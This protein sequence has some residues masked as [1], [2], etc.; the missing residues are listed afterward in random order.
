MLD[1]F[2]RRMLAMFGNTWA[3]Q[4]GE[5]P[6]GITSDTW[7]GVL[8]GVTGPQIAA[9]LHA[10]AAEGREFPPNAPRF[11]AM[12]LGIPSFARVR[13]EIT[14][15]GME[16]SPFTRSVWTFVDGHDYRHASAKDADRILQAAYDAAHDLAM[17]GEPLP[18][19]AAAELEHEAPPP[20][21]LPD[22]KEARIEHMRALLG[23]DFNPAAAQAADEAVPA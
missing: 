23:D 10:C 4:Y 16:R 2:W 15:S 7:A 3:S 14:Q 17:R 13:L 1:Q 20:V 5:R 21:V 9:G 19:P 8:S 22:T 18:Q 12:C 11:R 6:D